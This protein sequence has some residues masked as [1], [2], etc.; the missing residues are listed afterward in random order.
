MPC[1]PPML[2]KG[3]IP[4]YK[5]NATQLRKGIKVELEHTNNKALAKQIAKAHLIEN[6][7]Y[8]I[9]LKKM[10]NMMARQRK[11]QFTPVFTMPTR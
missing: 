9:Y 6:P 5:F 7:E 11:R 10:E 3:Y 1:K 4:D 2:K 8:Y